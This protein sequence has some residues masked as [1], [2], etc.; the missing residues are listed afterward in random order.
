[1][2]ILDPISQIER[3]DFVFSFNRLDITTPAVVHILA[4]DVRN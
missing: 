1:V 4:R 3:W 2:K